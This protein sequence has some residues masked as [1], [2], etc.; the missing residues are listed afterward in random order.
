MQG[1]ALR[2]A[3][4][5]LGMTQAQLAE[6]LGLRSNTVARYERGI[7]VIPKVVELAVEALLVRSR[8]GKGQT[9]ESRKG[10]WK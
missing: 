1:E 4:E 8:K 7:L 6:Q 5:K 2:A 9:G 3:R 10:A